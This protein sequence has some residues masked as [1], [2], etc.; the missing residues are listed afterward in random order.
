LIIIIILQFV[1]LLIEYLVA[2]AISKQNPFTVIKAMI[3]AYLTAFGTMSS[4][5]TMPVSL[6]SAKKVPFMKK[7][8]ADFV[9]PLCST[10]HLSGAAMTITIS[11]IT[12]SLLT[13]GTLPPIGTMITFIILLGVIEVGAVGVPGGSAM[14]ALG[15]LQSTLGFSEAALGLMLTLFMIQDSFGTAANIAGDGAI[16]MV[17]NKIFGKTNSKER[18]AN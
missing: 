3:P 11:A 15:I 13:Q 16:A 18:S 5:A 8:I 14:A 6:E 9:M 10:V 12:V 7:E 17:V 2:G 1:W 4:A